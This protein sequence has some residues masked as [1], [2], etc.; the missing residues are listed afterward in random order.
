M[1]PLVSFQGTSLKKLARELAR[2]QRLHQP[3][4]ALTIDNRSS[5]KN[6]S[7]QDSKKQPNGSFKLQIF[8]F[9]M[10]L[11]LQR[12]QQI[13]MKHQATEKVTKPSAWQKE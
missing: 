6:T 3:L 7:D 10:Y 13:L 4:P 9:M 12:Q 8:P 2:S 5:S 1:H 11:R